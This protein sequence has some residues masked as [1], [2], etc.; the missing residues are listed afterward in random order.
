M[1]NE[2]KIRA[3]AKELKFIVDAVVAGQ[4]NGGL[5]LHAETSEGKQVMVFLDEPF[6]ITRP[7]VEQVKAKILRP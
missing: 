4:G 7:T 3:A 6:W 2:E 1:S 5:T